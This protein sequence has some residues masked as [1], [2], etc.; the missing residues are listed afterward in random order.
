M[1]IPAQPTSG[2]EVLDAYARAY[3]ELAFGNVS[4]EEAVEM[5]FEEADF[6]LGG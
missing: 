1:P 6:I 3:S 4:L 2:G 5:F